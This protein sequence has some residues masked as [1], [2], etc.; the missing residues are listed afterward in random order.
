M[1][2]ANCGDDSNGRPIGY[3]HEGTCDQEGCD[4]KIVRGLAFVC[5]QMHGSDEV[6]CEKYFCGKHKANYVMSPS[7]ET[8]VCDECAK[9]LINSGDWVLDEDED[10]I[11]RS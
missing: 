4:E 10:A 8:Q 1:G 2:W 6:S 9:T 11:I 7:I 3:A 5:G